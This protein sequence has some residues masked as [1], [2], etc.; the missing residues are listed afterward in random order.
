MVK[1]L[2]GKPYEWLRS[3]CFFSPEDTRLRG[4]LITANN[5]LKGGKCT[6]KVLICSAEHQ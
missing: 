4:A 3:L 1:D 5:F 2:K 6:R